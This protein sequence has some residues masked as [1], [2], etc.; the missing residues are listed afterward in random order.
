M[1]QVTLSILALFGLLSLALGYGAKL[2]REVD[3]FFHAWRGPAAR[4]RRWRRSRQH[5]QQ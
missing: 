5:H 4:L 2:G 3:D 1:D